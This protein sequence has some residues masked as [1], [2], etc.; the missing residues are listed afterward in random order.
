MVGLNDIDF[1][2]YNRSF[3]SIMERNMFVG[4]NNPEVRRI[5]VHSIPVK[6]HD[7]L[8]LHRELAPVAYG[9]LSYFRCQNRLQCTRD[10]CR[11]GL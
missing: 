3:R 8:L 7:V 6:V 10:C 5:M 2:L 9:C 1:S 4:I 11:R